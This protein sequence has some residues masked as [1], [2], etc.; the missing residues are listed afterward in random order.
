M[1]R[2]K[3][4]AP[5]VAMVP[6]EALFPPQGFVLFSRVDKIR[7]SAAKTRGYVNTLE[8]YCT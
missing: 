4:A 5:E 6:G 2:E 3:G 8:Y 7:K 1:E